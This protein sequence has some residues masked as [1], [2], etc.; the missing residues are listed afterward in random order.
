MQMLGVCVSYETR[1]K[2]MLMEGRENMGD[3]TH[4]T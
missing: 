2:D 1:R 4:V 3:R